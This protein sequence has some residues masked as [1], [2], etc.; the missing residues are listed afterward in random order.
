MTGRSPLDLLSDY[1]RG[2]FFLATEERTLLGRGVHTTVC[3][4]DEFALAERVRTVLRGDREDTVG[5]PRIAVGAL[6]FHSDAATPGHIVV[7]AE[8]HVTGSV[9]PEAAWSP[10]RRMRAPSTIRP[11][12]EPAQHTKAVAA[13]VTALEERNLRKVVLARA[14]DVELGA[15]A[16]PEDVLHNLVVD[17]ERGYTFA[18]ELPNGRTLLGAS[19]ELLLSRRGGTVVSHPHA[20]SAPRSADP[21]TDAE[22]AQAL[23]VSRKDHFEHAVLTEAIVE[24]LRPYCRRLTVPSRPTLVSTPT[25]WHLG[26]TI[27]GELSDPDV[28]ALHL[29]AALHPTPAI[30]GTPT[31]SARQLVTELEEFDRGYYAGTVGWVDAEGDGE[32]AVSIRCAEV[33]EQ[34]LR[35]YAGGGIVPESD[36]KAELEE[37]SAKFATLLRA[38]GLSQ[39]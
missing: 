11:V 14:L 6:P 8:T 28:T 22:H 3:D 25:M 32:W 20:G 16:R 15:P 24:T 2:D 34:S 31:S 17:N 37:T 30:C 21:N 19:P 9:H 1:R 39:E 5:G 10:R 4:A 18:A 35:L 29:A 33:A 38:M 26:T 23:L 13:A 7:P 36:P 27:T 12:P